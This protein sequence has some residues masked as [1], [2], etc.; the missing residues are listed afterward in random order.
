MANPFWQAHRGLV[1]SNPDA[2][3]A[4]WI[5]AALLRPRF[6]TLLSIAR[7][8]GLERLRT[9]WQALEVDGV[10]HLERARPHVERI[11]RN[12]DVGFQRAASP[13]W[14]A[15]GSQIV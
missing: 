10:R 2:D 12:I 15:K 8:F 5:R 4:V 3:D 13:R 11:L 7:E 14:R 6:G 1:W 9:E